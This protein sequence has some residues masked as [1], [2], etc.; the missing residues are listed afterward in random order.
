VHDLVEK[1]RYYLAHE[2]ERSAIAHAG[3]ERTLK[4]HTYLQRMKEL[5]QIIEAYS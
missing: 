5:E 3:Q 4:D 1:I 2:E